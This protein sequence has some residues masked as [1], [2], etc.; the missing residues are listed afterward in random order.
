MTWTTK[1][2]CRGIG[3]AIFY[4]QATQ[5][6]QGAGE[7]RKE[8]RAYCE[9]CEVRADCL[10]HALSHE[11][12]GMWGGTTDRQRRMIRRQRGLKLSDPGAGQLVYELSSRTLTGL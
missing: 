2:A 1:A 3:P 10:E 6:D 8:A 12:K 7:K 5:N 9:S 11:S 4:P